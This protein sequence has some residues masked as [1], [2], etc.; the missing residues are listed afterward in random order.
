MQ[1]VHDSFYMFLSL[2]GWRADIMGDAGWLCHL[3]RHIN[4]TLD[5]IIQVT[6]IFLYRFKKKNKLKKNYE[7]RLEPFKSMQLQRPDD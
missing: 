6:K 1:A 3:L 4:I 7:N 5:T 2:P